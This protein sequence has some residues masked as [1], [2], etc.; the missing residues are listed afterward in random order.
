FNCVFWCHTFPPLYFGLC[1]DMWAGKK[2]YPSCTVLPITP[3]RSYRGFPAFAGSNPDY[4]FNG[5]DK[6]LS[7]TDLAGLCCLFYRTNDL[8]YKSICCN[9]LQFYLW[10]KVNNV[11]GTSIELGMAFLP[12]EPFYFCNGQTLNT[13]FIQG[14][15]HLIKFKGF[16]Y[17]LHFFHVSPPIIRQSTRVIYLVTGRPRGITA[18]LAFCEA[19]SEK[20]LVKIFRPLR[21]YLKEP[22]SFHHDFLQIYF[23]VSQPVIYHRLGDLYVE[24]KGICI[25]AVAKGLIGIEG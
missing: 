17:R 10:D 2:I 11:L 8:W 12:S 1:A 19:C 22:L 3:C 14:I 24:L 15:L 9:Y 5:M 16:Y 20:S 21:V 13:Y 23:L 25:A 18:L 4:L 6:Y 7:I